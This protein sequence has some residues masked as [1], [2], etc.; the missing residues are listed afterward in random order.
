MISL[1]N[2][3]AEGQSNPCAGIFLARVKSLEDAEDAL[4][5]FRSDANAV[6]AHGETPGFVY[7]LRKYM[8]NR[9]ST[10]TA[11]LDCVAQEILEQLLEM[12]GQPAVPVDPLAALRVD[13]GQHLDEP[14]DLE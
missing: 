11:V 8:D 6:V 3:L 1:H 4:V 12:C 13:P 7:P 10:W 14:F 5:E 9:L 2:A